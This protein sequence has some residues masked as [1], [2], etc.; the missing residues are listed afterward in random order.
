MIIRKRD[1]G[2]VPRSR[3]EWIKATSSLTLVLAIG[4][5]NIRSVAQA[6]DSGSKTGSVKKS[7]TTKNASQ[8]TAKSTAKTGA[9]TAVKSTVAKP[10]TKAAKPSAPKPATAKPAT[11]PASN[12]TPKPETSAAPNSQAALIESKVTVNE[13]G[14]QTR[15][16]KLSKTMITFKIVKLPGGT[17]TMPDAKAP[18]GTKEVAIKPFWIG[19]KEVS[20]DEYD[21]YMFKL[22]MTDAEAAKVDVKLR[23]SLPYGAPDRGYGHEGYAAI[24]IA[25]N[26]AEQ[27]CK[28][29]SNKTGKKY[30]LPTE[31]EW[32]FAARA[33]GEG[34][35]TAEELQN[36]AWV[37]ENS[38]DTTHPIGEKKPNAWGLYD[39]FGNAG[40]WVQG[41]DGDWVIKG[42]SFKEPAIKV[43]AQ[44]RAKQTDAWHDPNKPKSNWWL[45]DAPF[46]GFRVVCEE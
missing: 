10:A 42:G 11:A 16:E 3:S 28:W 36:V 35:M 45:A 44:W 22:D 21:A 29:L 38:S 26:G 37:Q 12:P 7:T 25:R 27:Y 40:E 8:K 2:M 6:G 1:V 14:T 46:A 39:M 4:A 23:P 33:G 17:I 20:W 30:R 34:K 32:E 9:K 31:A 41:N 5:L 43:N 13:G 19:E 15:E 24:S 18:G